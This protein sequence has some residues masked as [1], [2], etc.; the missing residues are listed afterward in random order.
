MSVVVESSPGGGENMTQASVEERLDRLE[1]LVDTVLDRI[2]NEE[3]RPKNWRRTIGMF[4]ADPIMKEVIDGAL[5]SREEERAR[6][7]EEFDKQNGQS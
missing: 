5:R 1:R 7:Y 3:P 6:F 2:S 4:D